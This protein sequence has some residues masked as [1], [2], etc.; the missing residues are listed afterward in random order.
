MVTSA[1]IWAAFRA[2]HRYCAQVGGAGK[3]RVPRTIGLMPAAAD[4]KAVFAIKEQVHVVRAD[5]PID[6]TA[7]Y[8]AYLYLWAQLLR[9]SQPLH[10]RMPES[11]KWRNLCWFPIDVLR[12]RNDAVAFA[13]FRKWYYEWIQKEHPRPTEDQLD[14]YF[15][16][17]PEYSP[18][19]EAAEARRQLQ[20]LLAVAQEDDLEVA[21][22][23]QHVAPNGKPRKPR[24][25]SWHPW[26]V[27]AYADVVRVGPSGEDELSVLLDEAPDALARWH[28]FLTHARPDTCTQ[29]RVLSKL[30]Q[31]VTTLTVGQ[32][33][34]WRTRL[35]RERR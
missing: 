20:V 18:A 30:D 25:P 4:A 11:G 24:D 32:Q 10:P 5:H 35:K 19:R 13:A 29:T 28:A 9:V 15:P 34:R 23:F 1:T 16:W 3:L 27:L 8:Y 14:V 17:I 21:T 2:L 6:C 33:R 7:V 31:V 12:A 22:A 26:L